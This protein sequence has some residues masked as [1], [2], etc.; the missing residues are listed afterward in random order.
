MLCP[1]EVLQI[2]QKPDPS[3]AMQRTNPEIQDNERTPF[4]FDRLCNRLETD[5]C[6]IGVPTGE[7]RLE[8]SMIIF[9]MGG[10]SQDR[11]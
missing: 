9:Q 4:V 8:D 5:P 3:L 11:S 7:V 10:A 1:P 6:D 2:S